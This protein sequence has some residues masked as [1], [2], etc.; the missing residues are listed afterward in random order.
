MD[1]RFLY[2]TIGHR[3]MAIC[4]PVASSQLD[5]V[6]SVVA[7]LRD[8]ARAVDVGCGKAELLIRLA[9]RSGC[10]GLG[11]D[12]NPEFVGEA[13]RAA[14]ARAAG[15]VEVRE[16]KAREEDLPPGRHDVSALVGATHAF[17]DTRSAIRALARTTRSGGFVVLGEGYWRTAP[18]DSAR[19]RMGVARGELL[20][21]CELLRAIERE[22]L[23]PVRVA[24]AR[25]EDW[26]RYEQSHRANLE[27]FWRAHPGDPLAERLWS[28]RQA[29]DEVY[30]GA[31]RG[32]MGFAL[33]AARR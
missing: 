33:I 16:A 24:E 5:E 19:D 9:E 30:R 7:P 3:G 6:L 14:R 21:L 18:D 26:D 15:L 25:V 20:L 8:G 10:R 13:R 22:G 27:A 4:N 23:E 32:V 28:R 29:W 11:I 2:T 17:G 12:P 1:E 31:A